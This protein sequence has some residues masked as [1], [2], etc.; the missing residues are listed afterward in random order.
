M[1]FNET[2]IDYYDSVFE[3]EWRPITRMKNGEK[4]LIGSP[5]LICSYFL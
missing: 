1:S 4:Q 3:F 2:E 5:G